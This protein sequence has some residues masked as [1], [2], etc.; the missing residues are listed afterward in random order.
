MAKSPI[1][2]TVLRI[3]GPV[4]IVVGVLG[5]VLPASAAMTSGAAPY[6]IFHL[7][8][9]ALGIGLALSKNLSAIKAFNVGFGAIDLYQAVASLLHL[10]PEQH[11]AWTR[12]DDVLHVVIGTAL[13]LVGLLADRV[14]T[15]TPARS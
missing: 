5:F 8:F 9:G 13:V 15:P 14:A 10:W 3:F 2:L 11:F 1:N 6:N 7:C 12:V 4:L